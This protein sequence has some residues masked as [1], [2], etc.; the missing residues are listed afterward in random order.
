[1]SH[2]LLDK[3]G[4]ARSLFRAGGPRALREWRRL[5][6]LP[7]HVAG[8]TT[9]LGTPIRFTD[10]ASFL[11]AYEEIFLHEIYGFAPSRR[12]PRIIDCGANIG[13]AVLYWK[14]RWPDARVI[15]FEPDPAAYAA[16]LSNCAVFGHHDVEAVCKAVWTAHGPLAF[17]REGADA[18]RLGCVRAEKG[19]CTV[20][21][22]RLRDALG[23]GPVDLLKLDIEGAE[24]DVVADCA[25]RLD[26][27]EHIFVEF[28]SFLGTEQ[29]LDELWQHL[30]AAGFRLHVQATYASPRPFVLRPSSE[31]MDLRL[32]VFGWR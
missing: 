10:A 3:L 15:A 20:E 30:R 26:A 11:S 22:Y 8:T 23:G 12:A 28:H 1:M 31:G 21:G 32:N 14:R 5:R 7:R 19:N 25:G 13:L 2:S 6:A 9:I 16:L 29:R 17:V 24:V 4:R 27:V 18:G